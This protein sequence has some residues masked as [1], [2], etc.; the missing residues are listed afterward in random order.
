MEFDPI[1]LFVKHDCMMI[2]L[3]LRYLYC[4]RTN[5]Q[6]RLQSPIYRLLPSLLLLLDLLEYIK[7]H[8]FRDGRKVL[9][10]RLE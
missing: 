6:D 2:V 10:E 7:R 4:H 9:F 8:D 3:K 5:R 1:C